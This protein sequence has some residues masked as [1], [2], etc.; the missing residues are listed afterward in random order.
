MLEPGF[1]GARPLFVGDDLTDEDA[2][3][4]AAEL[5]WGRD[6]GRGRSAATAAKWR[7]GGVAAVSAWLNEA[8]A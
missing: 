3:R 4:A 8:A 2:F 1:I 7:L 5:G 6:T